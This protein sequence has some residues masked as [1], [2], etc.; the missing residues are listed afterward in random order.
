MSQ[1]DDDQH[2]VTLRR[3]KKLSICENQLFK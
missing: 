1:Q 3:Q 2:N